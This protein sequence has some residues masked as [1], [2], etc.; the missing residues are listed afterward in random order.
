MVMDLL[1]HTDLVTVDRL[2][3]MCASNLVLVYKAAHG[4][5]KAKAR[6]VQL[7]LLL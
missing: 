4:Q 7:Y 1:M 5:A 2:A 3:E 6:K